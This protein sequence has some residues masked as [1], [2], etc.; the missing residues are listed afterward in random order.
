MRRTA[1]LLAAALSTAVLLPAPAALAAEAC[2]PGPVEL[3]TAGGALLVAGDEHVQGYVLR[4][5]LGA[6]RSCVVPGAVVHLSARTK[7]DTRVVRVRT[8]T[9]D[10]AG[11][12]QFRVRPPYTTVLT[13][14]SE[15]TSEVPAASAAQ[16]LLQVGVRVTLTARPVSGCAVEVSGRT[17]PAK[18]GSYVAFPGD[19]RAPLRSDGTY[20]G[21]VPRDCGATAPLVGYV[22]PSHRNE[23]GDTRVP[24][25]PDP[26]PVTCGTSPGSAGPPGLTQRLEVFN[27]TT[28]V[29]GSWYGERVVA[30][31][32]DQPVTFSSGRH[33]TSSEPYRVLRN[34]TTDVLGREGWTDAGEPARSRTL[35]PGEEVRTPVQLRARNCE[36][37]QDVPAF[38]SSYGPPLPR[39]R[40]VGVSVLLVGDDARPWASDRVALDVE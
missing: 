1:A 20:R 23:A 19:V 2:G 38:A 34:G 40:V 30:N 37:P 35:Q 15:A 26:T 13:A 27:T 14:S 33:F 24:E 7:N 25:A 9:T 32:T 17:Y 21:V 3:V 39:G 12:V 10:A 6:G 28:V 8:A 4:R 31:P 36:A 16:A 29:G 5:R 11:R 18:P 22:P